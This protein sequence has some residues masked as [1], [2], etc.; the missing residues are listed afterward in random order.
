MSPM[1]PLSLLSSVEVG[2]VTEAWLGEACLLLLPSPP[3]GG[4]SV[5]HGEALLLARLEEGEILCGE[6]K[7]RLYFHLSVCMNIGSTACYI[8]IM[9]L[10]IIYESMFAFATKGMHY[11]GVFLLQHIQTSAVTRIKLQK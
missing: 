8:Y 10:S 11:Y 1:M 6:K 7:R 4:C 2:E 9:L 5:E 3:A